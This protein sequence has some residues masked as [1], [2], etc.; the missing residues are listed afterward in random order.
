MGASTPPLYD[1]AM[2]AFD[3]ESR[4][5]EAVNGICSDPDVC[6]EDREPPQEFSLGDDLPAARYFAGTPMPRDPLH[7]L[8]EDAE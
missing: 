6:E 3:A 8:G 7:Q 1:A 2:R 4:K 5:Q